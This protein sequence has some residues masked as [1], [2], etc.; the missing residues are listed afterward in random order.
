MQVS[1]KVRPIL[2]SWE[3]FQDDIQALPLRYDDSGGY[4]LVDRL[5]LT[6]GAEAEVSSSN[7]RRC[8]FGE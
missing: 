3:A 5:E 4:R 8:L 6:V 2:G 1:G 7:S